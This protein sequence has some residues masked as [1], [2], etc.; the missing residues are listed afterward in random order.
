MENGHKTW[1]L[2]CHEFLRIKVTEDSQKRIGI[3]KLQLVGVHWTRNA[4][5]EQRITLF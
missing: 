5:N 2:E 3:Y 1:N 4:M